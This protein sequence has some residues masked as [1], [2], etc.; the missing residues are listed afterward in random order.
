[1]LFRAEV[2][3]AF[4][5]RPLCRWLSCG[6]S[7][8]L[9]C[10]GRGAASPGRPSS[11]PKGCACTSPLIKRVDGS[12]WA[13]C[14]ST[15]SHPRI[16]SP[17]SRFCHAQASPRDSATRGRHGTAACLRGSARGAAA[18]KAS[19]LL[20]KRQLVTAARLVACHSLFLGRERIAL[21][22]PRKRRLGRPAGPGPAAHAGR[23]I[24][25]AD[26]RGEQPTERSASEQV[27]RGDAACGDGSASRDTVSA[28]SGDGT[29]LDS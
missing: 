5:R 15:A 11:T 28:S 6:G 13:A 19:S 22:R 14:G 7:A 10:G 4:V 24:L 25:A 2:V 18:H 3:V 8:V 26:A 16:L 9:S 12:R 17:K 20:P 21:S 27:G 23:H 29:V 1:M